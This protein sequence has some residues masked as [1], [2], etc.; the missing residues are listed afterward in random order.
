MKLDIQTIPLKEMRY[1]TLGDYW[2][3]WANRGEVVIRVRIAAELTD[4]AQALLLMH[5]LH[6]MFLCAEVGI[7]FEEIDKWD[8]WFEVNG[9][10]DE[11]GDDIRAPYHI[12]HVQAEALERVFAVFL[13]RNWEDYVREFQR[14]SSMLDDLVKA[15]HWDSVLKS[16]RQ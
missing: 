6:E 11:P 16:K 3:D 5:E 12:Q 9:Q 7:P 13:G 4:N 10:G 2:E 14:V 1:P 15:G 8:T